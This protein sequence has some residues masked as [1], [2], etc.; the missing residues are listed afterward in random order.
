MSQVVTIILAGGQGSRLFPLT[1]IRS[2][3]AVP[4]AGRFRLIDIPISNC[5]HSNLK[6]I[7]ISTQ[8]SSES[9]HR[10]IFVTYRFDNFTKDFV[11]IL[12]AEQTLESR[13]WYQGTADAVR[14][15]LRFLR[16]EG[17][18][19]LILSGDHLY[20]M[21]Y[22]KFI[23]FHVAKKADISI[24]V[25]PVHYEQTPEFGVMKV[26]RNGRIESFFE[27]P[28]N[29]EDQEKMRVPQGFFNQ[30]GIDPAGHTHLASMGIY[31]F[32]WEVLKSL[33]E[34]TDFEDFGKGIIPHSLNKHKVYGYFYNGYWEDIGTIKSFFE[35]HM[36]LT[37]TLPKFNFYDEEKPIFTHPRFLPGSKILSAQ[38]TNSI[39]CEGSIIN[40]STV[41]QSIVGIRTRIGENSNIHRAVVMGSDFFESKEQ[42]MKNGEK[43]IPNIGIGNDC[44]IQNAIIDKN[45]RI[46]HGVKLVNERGIREEVTDNYVIRD[47][48]IVIPKNAVITNGTVI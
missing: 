25:H 8:F 45:A 6:K 43:G 40:R 19:I 2:K 9:L 17:D 42:L 22:R 15:N 1:K 23:D 28:K 36:D 27:K 37:S 7:F 10:H 47:G 34:K 11:T 4:I 31:L 14:Q 35:T 24:S 29:H 5:I 38:V 41:S 21:D 12:S 32:N 44:F 33:L 20:R 18:L 13:D 26:N 46:G 30:L 39:L 48:I 3:P 16:S